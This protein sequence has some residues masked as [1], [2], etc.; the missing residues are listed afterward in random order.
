MKS[1]L[2]SPFFILRRAQLTLL[3]MLLWCLLINI[4]TWA[5]YLR[6]I[7]MNGNVVNGDA[8]YPVGGN[9]VCGDARNKL[10]Q[11]YCYQHKE[12][13]TAAI[14]HVPVYHH[15][16]SRNEPGGKASNDNTRVGW[17]LVDNTGQEQAVWFDD[18]WYVAIT[19]SVAKMLFSNIMVIAS[20]NLHPFNRANA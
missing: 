17:V 20:V 3:L 15:T 8:K 5:T 6:V 14:T 1:L 10:S 16:W 4:G 2:H 11:L 12:D 13:H 19:N 18:Y 9:T 7:G